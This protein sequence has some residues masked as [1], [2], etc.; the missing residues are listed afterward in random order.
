MFSSL[1]LSSNNVVHAQASLFLS[2][3]VLFTIF[4]V[5]AASA[6]EG[7][8]KEKSRLCQLLKELGE[9]FMVFGSKNI[10]HTCLELYVIYKRSDNFISYVV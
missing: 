4:V 2:E 5:H 7:Q 10:L 3:A 1:D 8:V 6:V 9:K